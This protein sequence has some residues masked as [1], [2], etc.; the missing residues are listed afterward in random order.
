MDRNHLFVDPRGGARS[1]VEEFLILEPDTDLGLGTLLGVRAVDDVSSDVDGE[2]SSD[3]TRGGVEWLGGSEHLSSGED[4]VGAFP[5]HLDDWAHSH[6]GQKSRE[7]RLLGEISVVLLELVLS[8]LGH[9]EA[10]QLEAL[11]LESGDD[12][13][14]QTSLDA[15]RLDHD[16]SSFVFAHFRFIIR[17]HLIF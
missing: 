15:I 3:C 11:L 13:S 16:E 4:D 8:R 14:D 17:R 2:V 12:L 9:L 7:E 5:D 6:V 1:P 10:N